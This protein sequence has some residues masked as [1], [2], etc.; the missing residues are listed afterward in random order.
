M[1]FRN[2][3]L[4]CKFVLRMYCYF[5]TIVDCSRDVNETLGAETETFDFLSETRPRPR[6]S[7]TLPRPRPSSFG[8]ETRPRPRRWEAETETFFETLALWVTL[9]NLR[10]FSLM[11]IYLYNKR[12]YVCLF[13][14]HDLCSVWP[15]KRLGRSRRNLTHALMS[16]KGVFLAR[17]MSR[18]FTC[19]CES[20]GSTKHPALCVKAT[21]SELCSHYVRTTAAEATPSERLRNTIEL[22][23]Y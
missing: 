15:A 12:R 10:Y 18:S 14:C 19:A 2:S 5:K 11:E 6:P 9:N 8:S 4:C 17:S 23:I 22:Q 13:V 16:T 20:D 3:I 21:P 7:H 1:E